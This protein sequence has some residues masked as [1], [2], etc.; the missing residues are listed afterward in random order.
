MRCP[1]GPMTR[2]STRCSRRP[3]ASA[4]CTHGTSRRPAR[5]ARSGVGAGTAPRPPTR[6]PA[7]APEPPIDEDAVREAA[8]RL[9][10]AAR[11]LIVAGGGAQDAS[12]EVTELSRMLQAPV[13][14]FRRGRGVLDGRDPFSV[15]LPLG[16]ELWGEANALLGVGTRL[17]YGFHQWGIDDKLA[18]IRVDAD[19]EEPE[20]FRPPAVA[21]VGDA[22]PILRR[23]I[24]ALGA[25]N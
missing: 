11:V 22:A 23:L 17:F 16:H 24:E 6:P 25:H 7:P 18:V 13:M 8:K 2:C 14:A 9:G 1:G 4:L 19:P 3:T 5:E 20:R 12:A 21:L 15:T 10:S